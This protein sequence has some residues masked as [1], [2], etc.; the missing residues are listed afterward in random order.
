[1]KKVGQYFV[2]IVVFCIILRTVPVWWWQRYADDFYD[3]SF[4]TC[5]V[6]ADGAFESI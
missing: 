2:S 5:K 4:E 6:M 1:M 3:P